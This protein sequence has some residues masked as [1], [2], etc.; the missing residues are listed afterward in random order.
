MNFPSP[1]SLP[2]F[3]VRHRFHVVLRHVAGGL[4]PPLTGIQ[5]LIIF[6]LT[7]LVCFFPL[8]KAENTGIIS[9]AIA[10]AEKLPLYSGQENISLLQQQQQEQQQSAKAEPATTQF[11]FTCESKVPGSVAWP[12][13]DR[14]HSVSVPHASVTT[15]DNGGRL[16]APAAYPPT[17]LPGRQM[18]DQTT[19]STA[20]T[21]S[22]AAQA[23]P[24][25]PAPPKKTRRQLNHELRQAARERRLDTQYANRRNPPR[26]E[27]IWICEFCEYEAIFK[28]PPRALIRKFELKDRRLRKEAAERQRLLE[29][30]Q[31]MR[32][33]KGKKNSKAASGK[34]NAASQD[35]TTPHGDTSAPAA[36]PPTQDQGPEDEEYGEEEEGYD[37]HEHEDGTE[38]G[39]QTEGIEDHGGGSSTERD[40]PL[41]PPTATHPNLENPAPT[42]AS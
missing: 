40:R 1:L 2:P 12:G 34:K 10:N 31:K 36:A 32:G 19:Q 27:D 15:R 21:P 33:R 24:A 11:T 4:C 29:K 39:M 5:L 6:L 37:D 30:A 28:E 3:T 23:A 18:A 35:R 14:R 16:S 17:A 7:F 22:D 26:D 13:T 38:S 41:R 25:P 42:T 9:T 20:A 8:V